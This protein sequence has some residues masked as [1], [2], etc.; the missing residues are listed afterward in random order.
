MESWQIT[1]IARPTP[2]SALAA[3]GMLLGS[4]PLAAADML[5]GSVSLAAAV[6]L[7]GSGPLA[8]AAAELSLARL[9]IIQQLVTNDN[10]NAVET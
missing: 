9:D 4:G 2:S 10:N 7:L 6:M 3:A 8:A 5:M 1:H